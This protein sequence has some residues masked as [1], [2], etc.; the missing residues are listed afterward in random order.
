MKRLSIVT[1]V[2]DG[3]RRDYGC[4]CAPNQQ[5][6]VEVQPKKLSHFG[7]PARS[8]RRL[9]CDDHFGTHLGPVVKV[10]DIGVHQP[11]ATR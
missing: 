4:N 2:A 10:H 9:L 1:L 11:E 5:A 6:S 8:Q 3:R 7:P